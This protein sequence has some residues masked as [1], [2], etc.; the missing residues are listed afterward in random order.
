MQFEEA[1]FHTP[2]W[3]DEM[4]TTPE[5]LICSCKQSGR[6]VNVFCNFCTRRGL[7]LFS[8]PMNG[9]TGGYTLHLLRGI[10]NVYEM[11]IFF[12]RSIRSEIV[13]NN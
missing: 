1:P 3:Q 7:L 13:S 8:L 12:S 9:R 6:V 5:K 4:K 10:E 2:L 11:Q